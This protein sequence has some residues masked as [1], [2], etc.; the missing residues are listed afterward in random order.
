MNS[1]LDRAYLRH[2]IFDRLI[3]PFLQ[4]NL[5]SDVHEATPPFFPE[6]GVF[7]ASANVGTTAIAV[8]RKRNVS[9][10]INFDIASS[11]ACHTSLKSRKSR[12]TRA[13]EP[14]AP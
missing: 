12:V 11:D 13:D 3:D 7:R 10:G 8:A 6:H 9:R 1:D 5:P 2:S 14:R 4:R